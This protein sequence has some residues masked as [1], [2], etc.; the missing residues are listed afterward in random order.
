MPQ[1]KRHLTNSG[2]FADFYDAL[3]AQPKEI[4]LGKPP[5]SNADKQKLPKLK[6][7][8]KANAKASI[9]RAIGLMATQKTS[10][11]DMRIIPEEEESS[12]IKQDN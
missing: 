11:T 4:K 12:R 8:L 5:Q 3:D 1:P 2:S 9:Q 10:V 7:R 6:L